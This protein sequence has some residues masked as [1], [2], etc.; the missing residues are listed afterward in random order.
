MKP[1]LISFK[2]CPL[3]QRVNIVLMKKSVD[4]DLVYVD[5]ASPPEW[6]R[7][8]SPFGQVLLLQV[9]EGVLFESVA[10]IEYLE[11]R[12]VPRLYPDDA[13]IRAQ[14]RSWVEQSGETTR[15]AFYLTV[16]ES[17]DEYVAVCKELSEKLVR[18]ESVLLSEPYFNGSE[19]GI[20]DASCAPFFQRVSFLEELR[21]GIV[22][23]DHLP[24]VGRWKDVLL[25]D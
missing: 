2:L 23:W 25:Q 19:F 21:S 22:D 12:F 11:D 8:L 18:L 15:A 17:E 6:F 5:L 13:Y 4:Y 24:K 1:K 20:V 7:R 9:D 3:V 14:N 10:I 16:K